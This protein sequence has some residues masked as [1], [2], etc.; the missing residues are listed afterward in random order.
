[1]ETG[2]FAL[3]PDLATSLPGV[4]LPSSY[5]PFGP[6]GMLKRFAAFANREHK[7]GTKTHAIAEKWNRTPHAGYPF[8]LQT[9]A[10]LFGIFCSG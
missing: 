10:Q 7:T 8:T 3:P 1:M 6:F 2:Y 4:M 9:P 5:F